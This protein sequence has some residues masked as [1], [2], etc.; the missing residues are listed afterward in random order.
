MVVQREIPASGN[1]DPIQVAQ[2]Q[3]VSFKL[4]PRIPHDSDETPIYIRQSGPNGFTAYG[5][6]VNTIRGCPT[7]EFNP[8]SCNSFGSYARKMYFNVTN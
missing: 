7:T 1:G 2:L 4:D 3:S 8:L 5:I 6:G